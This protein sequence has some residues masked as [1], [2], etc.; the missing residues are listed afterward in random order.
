[1]LIPPRV[2]R[3]L[4]FRRRRFFQTNPVNESE[5][6]IKPE[7]FLWSRDEQRK[8]VQTTRQRSLHPSTR[9]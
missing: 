1:M 8:N 5:E 3:V 7:Q 2:S 9:I 6:A 4:S